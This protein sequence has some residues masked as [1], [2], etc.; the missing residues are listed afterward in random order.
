MS[1]INHRLIGDL[2]ATRSLVMAPISRGRDVTMDLVI[3]NIPAGRSVVGAVFTAK[4]NL[5]D[6]DDAAMLRKYVTSTLS[7]DGQLY[8]AIETVLG[9]LTFTALELDNTPSPLYADL[10]VILDNG[11]Q[12]VACFPGVMLVITPATDAAIPEAGFI[13]AG[14]TNKWDPFADNSST[15]I[16]DTVGGNHALF[17]GG[18]PARSNGLLTHTGAEYARTAASLPIVAP[19][20]YQAVM[21]HT[22]TSGTQGLMGGASD[23]GLGAGLMAFKVAATQV[24][25]IR[26]AIGGRS[27]DLPS[28]T[29]N[30]QTV[31]ATLALTVDIFGVAR[32]YYNAKLFVTVDVAVLI[33]FMSTSGQFDIGRGGGAVNW[34]GD[35]GIALRYNAVAL[36]Q[37]ALKQNHVAARLLYPT[38][39]LAL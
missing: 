24:N 22:G 15:Q 16:T 26:A 7:A 37:S 25:I 8:T 1:F 33:P 13:T 12:Y 38:L 10:V 21:R 14:L 27:L 4:Q 20:T 31:P 17:V 5:S 23:G 39:P 6:S 28:G 36:G 2:S 34:I 32:L 19:F 35:I 3:R 11:A 18:T 30:T 29:L 9:S